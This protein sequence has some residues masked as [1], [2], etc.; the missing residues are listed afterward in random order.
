M[1]KLSIQRLTTSMIFFTTQCLSCH[2]SAE[3]YSLISYSNGSR[4]LTSSSVLSSLSS[5]NC[6]FRPG[7]MAD[8][9]GS[10]AD[11]GLDSWTLFGDCFSDA[12][13]AMACRDICRF[14]VESVGK[15]FRRVTT[16]DWD[17]PSTQTL[18]TSNNLSPG[19]NV[20]SSIAAPKITS[21]ASLVIFS[22]IF[23]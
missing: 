7:W 20:P 1:T 4:W 2:D 13:S 5:W 21:I 11:E 9:I 15:L 22:G 3:L 18:L 17:I 19:F 8:S 23:F 12:S 6:N 10:T 16:W 14:T